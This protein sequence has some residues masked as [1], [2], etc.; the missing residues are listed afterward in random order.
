M[1]KSTI[2]IL[3]GL[4]A[5]CNAQI[6]ITQNDLQP[7]DGYKKEYKRTFVPDSIISL[8]GQGNFT[9]NLTP[10]IEDTTSNGISFET[11]EILLNVNGTL[12][13]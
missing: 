11:T 3:L 5:F 10:F 8:D 6:T 7:I 4:I 9:L 13:K 12:F 1:T 2:S